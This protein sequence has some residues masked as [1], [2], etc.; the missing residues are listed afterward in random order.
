[1]G[2][3]RWL[4]NCRACRRD[5]F[6]ESH[7]AP[8]TENESN[9]HSLTAGEA[10]LAYSISSARR[11]VLCAGA[12]I[13]ARLL[14]ARS[15]V[16]CQIHRTAGCFPGCPD[17]RKPESRFSKTAALP[18]IVERVLF[19]ISAANYLALFSGFTLWATNDHFLDGTP[20]NGPF[21]APNLYSELK[22]VGRTALWYMEKLPYDGY[23]GCRSGFSKTQ[24]FHVFQCWNP[25]QSALFRLRCV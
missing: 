15:R 7:S 20:P 23:T 13:S 4:W 8:R 16:L 22:K 1:M 24:P 25:Q 19:R 14:V 11:P 6:R 21:N 18:R 5:G 2:T 3:A 12:V 10:R 17:S 9:T